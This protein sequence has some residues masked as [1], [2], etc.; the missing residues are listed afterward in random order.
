MSRIPDEIIEQIFD[1]AD[2]VEIVRESVT[3]K[4]TGSTFRGPCP[5]HQ[6]THPNFSV[7]PK[8]NMY[9][10]F[11]CNESG[12]V[13]T[14][15]QKRFGLDYPSAVREVARRY[16]IQIPE[17]KE[18]QGPDPHEALY[19]VCNVAQAWFTARLREAPDA[20]TARRYLQNRQ[21]DLATSF[22]TGLGYAPK[23]QEFVTEMKTLG[24]ADDHL[25]E[26]GLARRKDDGSLRSYFWDR[27]LIPIHDLR[28]RIVAFGGRILGHGEP[29][30]LNTPETPIFR[31]GWQLFNLH[32]ARSA[33]RKEEYC[34]LVEGYFDV[35][36]L[37]YAGIENVVAPLGTALTP[38]Q[39]GIIRRYSAEV[40]ILY[41]SDT[42]GLKA[43]FRAG[44]ELLRQGV[45]V[46]VAT[47]PEGEDPDTLVQKGGADAFHALLKQT[48]D[49]FDR[50]LQLIERKGWASDIDKRRKALDRLLPSIRAASDPVTRDL[51]I[52]RASEVLG[53]S[54]ETIMTEAEEPERPTMRESA[55]PQTVSAPHRVVERYTTQRRSN[56]VPTA[57]IERKLL[58][59]LLTHPSWIARARDELSPDLFAVATLRRIYEA[60]VG[61]PDGAP[62]GDAAS[63][64]SDDELSAWNH[65]LTDVE[66]LGQDADQDYSD[67]I[68]SLEEMKLF[69]DIANS[70]TSERI[71]RRAALSP[72]ALIQYQSYV[73]NWHQ[74]P[75][76][77]TSTTSKG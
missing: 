43:T 64:L 34:V 57:T 6:G 11:V 37:K 53:I 19:E 4:R 72:G 16:G 54:K 9:H 68:H 18:A 55:P 51:Y 13:F 48:L 49:L 38:E 67:M 29:K 31:K 21:F 24:V 46:R 47:M 62:V 7:D 41:D 2:L 26:A 60:L 15:Y 74:P 42:P 52:S 76:K 10:C 58:R 73:K 35:L 71:R 63:V 22:E 77:P 32:S 59:L 50:Q 20:E 14:W 61:L 45:R 17:S 8:K 27:L 69:A 56:G 5:F 36:R 66:V 3:L 70:E 23:N 65:L 33:I 44:N 40:V 30:Y 75:S 39:A 28:G 12:T 25:I 1:T